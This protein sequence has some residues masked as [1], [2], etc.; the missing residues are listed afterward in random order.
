[1]NVILIEY[2]YYDQKSSEY[3]NE[4]I[5]Y[6]ESSLLIAQSLVF[7]NIHAYCFQLRCSY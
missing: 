2:Q 6:V 3:F 5:Q 7:S 4:K 1:M